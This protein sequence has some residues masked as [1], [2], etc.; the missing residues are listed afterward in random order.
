MAGGRTLV[1]D[2]EVAVDPRDTDQEV[3]N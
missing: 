1:H 3:T 2:P